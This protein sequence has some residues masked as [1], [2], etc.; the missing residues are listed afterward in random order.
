MRRIILSMS[1]SLDGFF[2]GPDRSIDWHMV[3][4][5]LHEYLNGQFTDVSA[6]CSAASTTNSWSRSGPTR[7]PTRR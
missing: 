3:D 2:E 7:R 5:E 6:F 4:D 1:I